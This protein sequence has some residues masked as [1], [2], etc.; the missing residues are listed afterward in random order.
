MPCPDRRGKL[1]AGSTA[2]LSR[3]LPVRA[4]SWTSRS[5]VD[6]ALSPDRLLG[7]GLSLGTDSALGVGSEV[8]LAW[9]PGSALQPSSTRS[10]VALD[11]EPG[12]GQTAWFPL[13][14]PTI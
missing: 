2:S 3:L 5:G 14:G 10:A 8:P 7:R 1:L 4:A 13:G 9:L 6:L 12:S 11:E